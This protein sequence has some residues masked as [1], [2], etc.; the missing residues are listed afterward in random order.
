[1][2]D[3]NPM[4]VNF[5]QLASAKCDPYSAKIL[6][7]KFG[8]D[9]SKSGRVYVDEQECQERL[10]NGTLPPVLTAKQFE[11]ISQGLPYGDLDSDD[12]S[13]I[14]ELSER[15][16]VSTQHAS[17]YSSH[18]EYQEFLQL[19]QPVRDAL[20][21]DFQNY[22][23]LKRR[24]ALQGVIDTVYGQLA[25]AARQADEQ[26]R[27]RANKLAIEEAGLRDPARYRAVASRLARSG[28]Y[29]GLKVE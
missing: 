17:P 28:N 6:R 7:L 15:M 5:D 12:M 27:S 4:I 2:N 13:T 8:L 23:F 20:R 11:R 22:L 29:P 25:G 24:G 18:P 14:S 9:E 1:M 19:S 16:Q 21:G 10:D 26:A 3:V